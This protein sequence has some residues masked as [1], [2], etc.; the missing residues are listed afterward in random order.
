[1]SEQFHF[2]PQKNFID[3]KDYTPEPVTLDTEPGRTKAP[4]A[5]TAEPN[6]F[7]FAPARKAE[8]GYWDEGRE[9]GT[10]PFQFAPGLVK[11]E[12]DPAGFFGTGEHEPAKRTEFHFYKNLQLD[13][14]DE[15]EEPGSFRK[16]RTDFSVGSTVRWLQGKK[17]FVIT[18]LLYVAKGL[19]LVHGDKLD[20]AGEIQ[21]I[22]SPS[23][24][25][26]VAA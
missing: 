13:D 10:E 17:S 19:Y 23:E 22:F 7:H 18:K 12:A 15:A 8:P 26:T 11:K 9:I 21:G 4:A 16:R 25:A 24:L 14:E 3:G 20:G 1:M 5:P 6:G 2:A